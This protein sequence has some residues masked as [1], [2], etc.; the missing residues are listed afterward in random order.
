MQLSP[1]LMALF[2]AKSK[3]KKLFFSTWNGRRQMAMRL[4]TFDGGRAHL[5][6]APLLIQ[7]GGKLGRKTKRPPIGMW[8]W[9]YQGPDLLT[10][11]QQL[12]P[13]LNWYQ[14]RVVAPWIADQPELP[15]EFLRTE[16]PA[17]KLTAKQR[18][19]LNP[20][21]KTWRDAWEE[22]KK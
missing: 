4:D 6:A 11:A 1:E 13:I 9:Y 14:Q 19:H 17:P 22:S 20:G 2:A 10:I 12:A 7:I 18:Y 3:K 21:D 15:I 16:K 8:E 5:E